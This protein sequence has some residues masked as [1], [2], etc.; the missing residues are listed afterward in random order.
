M[1]KVQ[2]IMLLKLDLYMPSLMTVPLLNRLLL[3]VLLEVVANREGEVDLG[4][5]D[6]FQEDL[7]QLEGI[8]EV[9]Q[10]ERQK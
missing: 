6:D 2:M 1:T 5:I 7:T 3:Q 10:Q 8:E 4:V 9:P